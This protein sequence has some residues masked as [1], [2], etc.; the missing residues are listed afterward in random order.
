MIYV[1]SISFQLSG[2]LLLLIF[3]VSAKR[4]KVLQR[5]A[6]TGIIVKDRNTN[7][8]LY[9]EDSLRKCFRDTYIN[10][11]AFIYIALGYFL[12][13]FGVNCRNSL[14]LVG[15]V[16]I[17]FASLIMFL[18]VIIISQI[19]ARSRSINRELSDDDL[20]GADVAPDMEVIFTKDIDEIMRENEK[21]N[22]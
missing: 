17:L 5:F 11:C 9:N 3:F 4:K 8:I 18:T 19:V 16:I 14:F 10:K 12:S 13:V 21:S 22:N 7:K 2:A 15:T 1:C 6:G 20:L